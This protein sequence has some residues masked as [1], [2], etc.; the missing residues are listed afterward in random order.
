MISNGKYYAQKYKKMGRGELLD[1]NRIKTIINWNL[2]A[3]GMKGCVVF[4]Y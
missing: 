2:R 3:P 4:L 1:E